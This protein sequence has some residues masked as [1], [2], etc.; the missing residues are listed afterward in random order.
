MK[1]SG[2]GCVAQGDTCER[3]DELPADCRA[4]PVGD[5]KYAIVDVI[6]YEKVRQLSWTLTPNGYPVHRE[7]HGGV[8]TTFLMGRYLTD[9]PE[10]LVV[11]FLNLNPLDCRR[12]NMRLCP[13]ALQLLNQPQRNNRSGFKG[14]AKHRRRWSAR[15]WD[16]HGKKLH[17]GHFA[18][19][20][21]AARAYDEYVRPRFGELA[22]YN[23]PREGERPARLIDGVDPES[24]MR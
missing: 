2:S 21:E 3:A 15:A 18:S 11:S 7:T 12:R 10:D 5:G 20:E 9:C 4:V 16:E 19:A 1:K 14:V 23:F 17:I 13:K 8:R 6:D 22:R 24:Q